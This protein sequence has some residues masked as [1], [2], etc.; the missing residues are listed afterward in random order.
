MEKHLIQYLR[1]RIQQQGAITFAEF[2]ETVL[3][4]ESGYYNQ[5]AK[6]MGQRGDFFT[7]VHL[8][9]AFGAMLAVQ[10]VELWQRLG[11]PSAFDLVEMGAGQGWLARDILIHLR[12]YYESC[13]ICVSYTIVEKSADLID[14]QQNTLQSLLDSGVAIQWRTWS[15]IDSQSIVGCVFSN[16][17]IDAFAVHQVQKRGDRLMEV[18]VAW[19][20]DR[21]VETLQPLST[22]GIAD[23][24][25]AAN[26][27]LL[28]PV[29]P[30]GY[31]TEV[32]LQAL[33][34]LKTV[35]DRLRQGYLITIDYGYSN[36]R[37]YNPGRCS[38]TLQC[39]YQH[40]V[41]GDPYINLGEQDITA[42]VDFTALQTQGARLGLVTL[43]LTQQAA[44]LMYL[45]LGDRIAG[46]SQGEGRS[47][48]EMLEQLKMRDA[49]HR[50]IDP[51]GLGGFGVL[52]QGKGDDGT[53]PPIRG[54][55]TAFWS[56]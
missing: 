55:T 43:G 3:Y 44:F 13:F 1:D 50:L 28:S 11:S 27:D 56:N 32:N 19:E 47:G 29:Y 46:L 14:R 15:E 45:G 8:G 24:F 33:D 12:D 30:E 4:H 38:G 40:Q 37:Y 9:E 51:T 31:R 36:K 22:S 23:Y 42:H 2:M 52:V 34:W 39:Y 48:A 41:H 18:Y 17:L 5:Q 25:Q 16:E 49:L 10:F 35:A 21:P 26:I 54:L 7:S 53:K 6:R 20:G